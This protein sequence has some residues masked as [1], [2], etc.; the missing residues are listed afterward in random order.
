MVLLYFTG[1]AVGVLAALLLKSTVFKLSLI[2]IYLQR[3]RQD[4]PAGSKQRP[5]PSARLLFAQT[6][7]GEGL[8]RHPADGGREP[9]RLSL[10]HILL[11][12]VVMP[13]SSTFSTFRAASAT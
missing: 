1:I 12:S 8:W 11:V 3:G 5:Q 9:G 10:I 4:L 7:P 6:V 2:H 13:T